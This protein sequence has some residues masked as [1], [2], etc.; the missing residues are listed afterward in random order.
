MSV[1]VNRI[2]KC[3]SRKHKFGGYGDPKCPEGLS[4][5]AALDTAVPNGD[6]DA[7][8][9]AKEQS[10][11]KVHSLYSTWGWG[12]L[13]V[14]DPKT[15]R[16]AN[17]KVRLNRTEFVEATR[18]IDK[19]II[20]SFN[21]L[22]EFKTWVDGT[23]GFGVYYD[24]REHKSGEGVKYGKPDMGIDIVSVAQIIVDADIQGMGISNHLKATLAKYADEHNV[25]LSE[26]PTN[27]GDGKLQ[28]GQDG[29]VENAL[30]HRARLERSY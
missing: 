4:I 22:S 19:T 11:L 26:T 21:N 28:E 20:P 1:R 5:K 3:Q 23:Y 30:A 14:S 25:I 15:G 18:A 7:F 8:F 12:D 2:K 10:N 13:H 27:A 6:L 24:L 16:G 29:W 9:S 17:V